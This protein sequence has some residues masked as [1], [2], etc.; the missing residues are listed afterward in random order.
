MFE[1]YPTKEE[2]QHQKMLEEEQE[3]EEIFRASRDYRMAYKKWRKKWR[4]DK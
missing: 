4:L 3:Q 1:H 2:I